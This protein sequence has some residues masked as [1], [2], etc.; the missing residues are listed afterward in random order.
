MASGRRAAELP[1]REMSMLD[2]WGKPEGV[3][4]VLGWAAAGAGAAGRTVGFGACP[5]RGGEQ[6]KRTAA[7]RREFFNEVPFTGI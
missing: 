1:V 2:P 4:A 5:R 6:R 3:F 7:T